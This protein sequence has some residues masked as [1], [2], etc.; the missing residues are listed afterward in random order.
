MA[1][2]LAN[3]FVRFTTV[4]EKRCDDADCLSSSASSEAEIWFGSAVSLRKKAL[5][6]AL[7]LSLNLKKNRIPEPVIPRRLVHF[8]ERG[9]GGV[10]LEYIG[11]SR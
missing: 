10:A 5:S 4:L 3:C 9:A 8:A 7:S 2:I 1:N 6:S 11:R